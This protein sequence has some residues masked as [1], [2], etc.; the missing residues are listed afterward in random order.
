MCSGLRFRGAGKTAASCADSSRSIFRAEVLIVDAARRLRTVNTRTPFD[1]V[2]IEFQNSPLAE[3]HFGHG[4]QCELRTFAENRAA[5]S[6]KDILHELLREGGSLHEGGSSF[7]VVRG[8]EF[9]RMPVET[10]V[11]IEARVFGGDDGMLEIG[12]DLAERNKLV[13]LVIRLVVNPAL[14]AALDVHR[15]GRRVDPPEEEKHQ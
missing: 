5:S 8:G 7:H 11:L 2:E 9:H 4:N 14:Q 12:R 13:A 15:G 10:M 3:D 1:D 6:E